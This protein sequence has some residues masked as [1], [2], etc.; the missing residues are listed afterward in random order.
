M[1]GDVK[2]EMWQR[3][4]IVSTRAV[5]LTGYFHPMSAVTSVLVYLECEMLTRYPVLTN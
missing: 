2:Q 4:K 5:D 1:S 3:G